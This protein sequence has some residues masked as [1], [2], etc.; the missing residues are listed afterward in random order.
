MTRGI[1]KLAGLFVCGAALAAPGLAGGRSALPTGSAATTL[2]TGCPQD[3]PLQATPP[4]QCLAIPSQLVTIVTNGSNG[5]CVTNYYVQVTPPKGSSYEAVWYS[6]IGLGT[7]WWTSP[8]TQYPD[9]V[10]GEGAS[11]K[12]PRGSAAWSGAG[13]A[14]PQPCP[15][16]PPAG[17]YGT[18]GWAVVGCDTAGLGYATDSPSASDA[19]A[20]DSSPTDQQQERWKILQDTQTK[21]FETVQDVTCNK[22]KTQDKA[23]KKW[24][25]YIKDGVKT[26]VK[27]PGK[28][29]SPVTLD[30]SIYGQST[31]SQSRDAGAASSKTIIVA[32]EWLTLRHT[33]TV[34]LNLPFTTSGRALIRRWLAADRRYLA[35]RSGRPPT[36]PLTTVANA[37][38]PSAGFP[39]PPS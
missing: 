35:H 32:Q 19:R 22:A 7:R 34:T 1:G 16:G 27:L 23:Y 3:G 4:E 39:A 36:V 29:S 24:D 38:E 5:G 28:L 21:I 30:M 15:S 18:A 13:G 25:E 14:G 26:K 11:Y 8:G 10:T 31:V 12:V 20:S 33:G 9:S 2:P 17:T 37:Y 6:T